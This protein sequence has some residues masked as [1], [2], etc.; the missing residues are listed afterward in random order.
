[1]LGDSESRTLPNTNTVKLSLVE[2][3]FGELEVA[4]SNPVTVT[5]ARVA[6]RPSTGLK[7]RR[8]RFESALVHHADVA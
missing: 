7:P 8:Q 5:N 4:G 1:M 6:E 2:R 3:E